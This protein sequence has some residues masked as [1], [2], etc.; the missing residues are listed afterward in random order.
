[1]GC[2]DMK[3][4][5]SL[6]ADWAEKPVAV[7]HPLASSLDD[8]THMAL[9]IWDALP[10]R[11][12]GE[13]A[14]SEDAPARENTPFEEAEDPSPAE[15]PPAGPG[16]VAAKCRVLK[17]VSFEDRD[18][19]LIDVSTGSKA[20]AVST[21]SAVSH[22]SRSSQTSTSSGTSASTNSLWLYYGGAPPVSCQSGTRVEHF[23]PGCFTPTGAIGGQGENP[24]GAA[25]GGQG[26]E[27]Q[28]G[29][30]NSRWGWKGEPPFCC[31]CASMRGLGRLSHFGCTTCKDRRKAFYKKTSWCRLTCK[32]CKRPRSEHLGAEGS[33]Y[34]RCPVAN[35]GQRTSS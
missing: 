7:R 23:C 19:Y 31:L 35:G 25:T 9:H 2:A 29:C 24:A 33:T 28:A 18:H 4:I 15:S 11:A 16:D 21:E 3:M 17:T 26:A 10:P 27:N 30:D 14:P 34:P 13:N 6:G 8:H 1:M 5:A 12:P 20:S 32:H 22:A